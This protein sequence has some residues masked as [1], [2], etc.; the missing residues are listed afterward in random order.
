MNSQK[1][2]TFP[3]LLLELKKHR[4]KGK[5]I[6]QCHGVFDLLHPGHIL[7]F[8]QA[9][10]LGDILVVSITPDKY[11][12]KGPGR[13]AFKEKLRLESLASMAYIDYA[14]LND[15][16]DAVSAIKLIKPDV[17]VKGSEYQNF[18][19][20]VTGKI[21]EEVDAIE[22]YGGKIHYTSGKV[23]S[24]S[25]LINKYLSPLSKD[26]K[27]FI[28]KI[29]KTYST[30]DLLEKI[31]QLSTLNVLVIGDAIIDIYQYVEPLGQSGKGIH[32]SVA[33]KDKEIFL[34]GS[35]IVARHLAQFAKSV[36]LLTSIGKDCP[37]NKKI[38]SQ[39]EKNISTHFVY[40]NNPS[41]LV[42]KRYVFKDGK[43]LT[44]MFET[45]SSNEQ[46]LDDE[47]TQYV[48]DYLK[49]EAKNFDLVVV[50][51][52]GNGFTNPIIT[53]AISE[54]NNFI[55]I[56]SQMNSGNRGYNVVTHYKRADFVSIN[57][58]ELRLAAHDRNSKIETLIKEV[59]NVMQ[60][61]AIAVTRGV[62]GAL[63]FSQDKT[64]IT[65][66]AFSLDSIDRVGAGDSFLAISSL[67]MA[68]KYSPILAGF[69]GSIASAIDVLIVGNKDPVRKVEFC[70]FL[71]RL[72]K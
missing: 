51:D 48:V 1:I 47:N 62:N 11:V 45:Y 53:K 44:K 41:S 34:G 70:K 46:L 33:C 56:N 63:L 28:Q 38:N 27:A 49:K 54:I 68:K 42:K 18:K 26:V 31:K 16:P 4:E 30:N 6:I 12:N 23:Y 59:S 25:S 60:N 55:A 10:S 13:P 14:I 9:K 24:S 37:Y 66:P 52:F 65:V 35:L 50:C 2:K 61:P 7:H 64:S 8:Q 43:T 72:M 58:P 21:K 69:F 29:K 17:Y 15:S 20:D 71:I 5:K 22:S 39:L 32:L 40:H 19:D 67:C 57:E 36:T 3:D